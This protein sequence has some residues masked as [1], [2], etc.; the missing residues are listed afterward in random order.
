MVL[1]HCCDYYN[2]DD[3]D[4]DI[5]GGNDDDDDVDNFDI[6]Q[7]HIHHANADSAKNPS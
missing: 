7:A 3:D 4:D 2:G 6:W 5:N 1:H